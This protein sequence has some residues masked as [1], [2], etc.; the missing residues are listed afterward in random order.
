MY[1]VILFAILKYYFNFHVKNFYFRLE[2]ICECYCDLWVIYFLK[3]KF[4]ETIN[5]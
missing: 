4:K 3:F 2:L 1:T 5:L